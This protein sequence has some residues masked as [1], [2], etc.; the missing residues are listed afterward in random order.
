MERYT[1]HFYLE[2]FDHFKYVKNT[3]QINCAY[4]PE[5]KRRPHPFNGAI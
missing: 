1:K 4:A 3:F 5:R 2:I